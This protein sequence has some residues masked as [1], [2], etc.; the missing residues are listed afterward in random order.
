MTVTM[1]PKALRDELKQAKDNNQSLSDENDS[2]K[3]RLAELEVLFANGGADNAGL[4]TRIKQLE[5]ALEKM[6]KRSDALAED[7]VNLKAQSRVSVQT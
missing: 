7:V 2:L 5:E 3:R 1:T 4:R 6:T